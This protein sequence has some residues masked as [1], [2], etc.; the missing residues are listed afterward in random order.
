MQVTHLSEAECSTI[1][2]SVHALVKHKA[3]LSHSVP[4]VVLYLTHALANLTRLRKRGLFYLS[5]LLTP[6][7]THL[8][9]WSVIYANSVQKR[10]NA[11]LPMWYKNLSI[12][13]TIPDKSGLLRDRFLIEQQ[14]VSL[15]A[16]ELAPCIPP[17]S[18]K[19]NWI[20]TLNDNNLPLFGKQIQF[21]P[22]RSTCTI[23]H[24]T[25]DCLS[26]PSDLITL[27]PCPGCNLNINKSSYLK[28]SVATG[29][30]SC[31]YSASL[32]QSWILPMKKSSI[33]NHTSSLTATVSWAE[34]MDFV[35]A[36]CNPSGCSMLAA[37]IPH[38]SFDI[39]DEALPTPHLFTAGDVAASS[40]VVLSLDSQYT[41]YTDD[42]SRYVVDWALTW[43]TLMFQPKFDNSFTKENVSRHHTLKFQLFLEDLPTLESLKRTRPDLY[44][45]ILTCRSCE[46][47]LEDFMHLFLCKK[48]RVKLHQILTSYL[49]HL[50]QKIKEADDN[51]NCDYS[52]S[53]NRV[54][55][56]PCW[57]FS[58]NNWYSS[59]RCY[60]CGRCHT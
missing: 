40:S 39:I 60:E 46:D 37:D 52:S 11:R 42:P 2:S 27:R 54:T 51:A 59:P 58:S 44:V 5:Q 4:N 12:N 14:P 10:G 55:S 17:S 29:S 43:H 23:V 47:R 8:L 1:T 19:K 6:Q 15:I 32:H 20:V 56:L 45:K 33:L 36:S 18:Y 9:S 3:K 16:K 31:S 25:S 49:H 7:G 34:I 13:V 48:R 35:T 24:W 38:T 50:I 28:K 30:V 26:R 21:Q 57:T 41:F 53:I 22:K